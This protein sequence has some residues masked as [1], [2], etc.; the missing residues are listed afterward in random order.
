MSIPRFITLVFALFLAGCGGPRLTPAQVSEQF[1]AKCGEGKYSEV[2]ESTTVPFRVE[3]TARYFEARVRDLQFDQTKSIEWQ[4]PAVKDDV[5]QRWG[6][7]TFQGGEKMTII[8]TM[9]LVAGNW[10]V[11]GITYVDGKARDDLFALRGRSTDTRNTASAAF[12]EPVTREVPTE[13]LLRKMVEKS[14]FDFGAAIKAKDFSEFLETVSDRWKYR[15]QSKKELDDDF[16]NEANRITV[17]KLNSAFRN[18]ID[19]GV[20]L[21]DITK[22]E[23]KLSEPARIN[24]DG[25]LLVNGEFSTTP[26][27]TT[28]KFEYYFEGGRWKLFGISIN[29]VMK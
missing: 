17:P 20:D 1:F 15:G 4:E 7:I 6:D 9:H 21:S 29:R 14:F 27:P 16:A 24:S 3:K 5:A 18:F 28:F 12:A 13:R 22:A 26:N 8:V 2:Y 25:V 11:H 10:R 23:M 19:S